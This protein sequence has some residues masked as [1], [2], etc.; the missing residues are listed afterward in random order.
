MEYTKYKSWSLIFIVAWAVSACTDEFAISVVSEPVT[1]TVTFSGEVS[2][3]KRNVSRAGDDEDESVWLDMKYDTWMWN[4]FEDESRKVPIDFVIHQQVTSTD[5]DVSNTAV[6]HLK[7]GE[8]NCLVCADGYTPLNWVS[9]TAQHLFHAWT[10]PAG[11]KMADARE[12]GTVDITRRNLD[13]EYFV[14]EMIDKLSYAEHGVTV[15]LRFKHLVGKLVIDKASLIYSDENENKDIWYNIRTISFPNMPTSG[16]FTTGIGSPEVMEVAHNNNRKGVTFHLAGNEE[17]NQYLK[18]HSIPFYILPVSFIDGNDY[19]KFFVTLAHPNG[20]FR[21]YEGNLKELV[22]EDA[23]D[24][25]LSEIKAGEC[26]TIRLVLKDDKVDGFFVYVSNWNTAE[27]QPVKDN[28]YPGIYTID[29]IVKIAEGDWDVFTLNP[30]DDMVYEITEDGKKVIRLY[31]NIDLS[32]YP[33]V[34]LLIIPEGY[35]LDGLGHNVIGNPRLQFQGD[36]RNLF[37]NGQSNGTS[38]D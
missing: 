10:E 14:G 1:D 19:G 18:N 33:D 20:E 8:T 7:P 30:T 9:K 6:Y 26:L 2:V 36:V 32:T 29:D 15:G 4:D 37:V 3:K 27:K 12:S 35:V 28:A 17:Y 21:I 16:N 24:N 23:H 25:T 13:Y 5:G 11:V 31:D 22:N 34:R 38:V